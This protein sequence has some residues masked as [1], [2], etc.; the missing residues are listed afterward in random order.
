LPAPN[1]YRALFR[2][3][4]PSINDYFSDFPLE[5]VLLFRLAP[6]MRFGQQNNCFLG[7]AIFIQQVLA[8]G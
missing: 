3:A 8:G 6:R 5:D 4:R 2:Y 7:F 1:A